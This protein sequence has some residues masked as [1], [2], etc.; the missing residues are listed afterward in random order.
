MFDA[1]SG[2]TSGT[3]VAA[4]LALT[5]ALALALTLTLALPLTLTLTLALALTLTLH[6][7]PH[8]R[9]NPNSNQVAAALVAGIGSVGSALLKAMEVGAPPTLIA[10]EGLQI[11]VQLVAPADVAKQPFVLPGADGRRLPL[12]Q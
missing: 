10:S 4:A 3:E 5:L 8:A 12:P 2:G 11:A 9:S 1:T 7:H 6:P